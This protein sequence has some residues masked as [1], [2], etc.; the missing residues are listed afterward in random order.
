MTTTKI[1]DKNIVFLYNHGNDLLAI[2]T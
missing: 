1:N 2:Q